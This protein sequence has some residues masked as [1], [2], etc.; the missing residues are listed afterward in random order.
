MFLGG[1]LVLFIYITSLASNEKFSF[2]WSGLIMLM[3]AFTLFFLGA[4]LC[5]VPSIEGGRTLADW[6]VVTPTLGLSGLV[7]KLYS[8]E[9]FKI[10]LLLVLYLLYALLVCAKIV[11]NYVG[12]LRNFN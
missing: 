4:C 6:G 12:A 10:T 2:S 11:N 3:G 8:T 7:I 9:R 1:V 5:G